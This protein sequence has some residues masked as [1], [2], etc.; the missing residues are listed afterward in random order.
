[1]FHTILTLAYIIPNIY[2]FL[3][4]GKLFVNREYRF[5]YALV[6]L[7][8]AVFFPL[9]N[10]LPAGDSGFLPIIANYLLPYYLYLL[11]AVLLFDVFFSCQQVCQSNA[12]RKDEKYWF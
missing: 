8:T 3:R 6:Y 2:I 11:L 5:Y 9:T 4:L 10:L 1:M 7:F 12:C